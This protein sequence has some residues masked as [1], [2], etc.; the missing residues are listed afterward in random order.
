MTW[1]THYNPNDQTIRVTL[2]DG[3]EATRR[4][5]R[6]FHYAVAVHVEDDPILGDH[7]RVLTWTQTVGGADKV[8][9][10]RGSEF[11]GTRILPVTDNRS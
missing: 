10:D 9:Q 5:N 3:K 2:P 6:P 7:W 11:S 1:T 8:V 4:T